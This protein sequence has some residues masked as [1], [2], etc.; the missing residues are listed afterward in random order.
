MLYLV[1]YDIRSNKIRKKLSD[2]LLVVGLERV[3]KS[4]FIGN[5]RKKSIDKV[6]DDFRERLEPEDKLYLISLTHEQLAQM[7][8]LGP[9]LSL[10]MLEGSRKVYTV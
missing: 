6:I 3:Q 9:V 10:D 2:K 7:Q 5:A 4:V 1:T 8:A